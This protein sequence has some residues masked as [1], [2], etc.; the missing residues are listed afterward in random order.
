MGSCCNYCSKD[1]SFDFA[2]LVKSPAQNHFIL[3]SREFRT[4]LDYLA[5]ATP[6]APLHWTVSNPDYSLDSS[7]DLESFWCNSVLDEAHAMIVSDLF[8]IEFFS[9]SIG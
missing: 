3:S 4:V 1:V 9:I 6:P 5:R 8:S 7:I 2:L